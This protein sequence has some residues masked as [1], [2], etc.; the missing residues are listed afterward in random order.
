MTATDNNSRERLV[1]RANRHS[2]TFATQKID[3]PNMPV[4]LTPYSIKGAMSLAANLREALKTE[5]LFRTEYCKVVVMVDAP[6]II[7]PLDLFEESES[8]LLYTHSYPDATNV[9]VMTNIISDLNTVV[10][11][12]IH[13]DLHNVINDNFSDVIFFHAS[14]PVWHNLLRRSFHGNKE[15]LYAYFHDQSMELISFGP[16]RF[17]YCNAFDTT[18]AHD[19]LY[20]ILSVWRHLSLREHHD[21][22]HL[23]GDLPER[24][25][26]ETE[27]KAY[28]KCVYSINPSSDFNRSP[29]TQIKAMPYDMTTYFIKG[30]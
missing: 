3:E 20:F 5:E 27:L 21:E 10:V 9:D 29:I 28:L 7:V 14:T 8:T 22:L 13:K 26:L 11:Y 24:Q 19:A 15:K 18:N 25:W 1:I 4:T 12:G 16:K 30:R 6:Y 23:V 17:K 2:L